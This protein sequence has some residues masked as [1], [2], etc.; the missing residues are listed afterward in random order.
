M[1]GKGQKRGRREISAAVQVGKDRDNMGWV[2]RL[3]SPM[4]KAWSKFTFTKIKRNKRGPGLWK[5]YSE[6]RSCSYEDVHVMWSILHNSQTFN[7]P[8]K[9]RFSRMHPVA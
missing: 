8:K 4:R 7:P 2:R 9:S 6:V 3:A 1:P 5:L